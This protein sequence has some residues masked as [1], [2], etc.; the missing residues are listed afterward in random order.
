MMEACK[1]LKRRLD[2][3]DF[4]KLWPGFHVFPFA[5]YDEKTVCFPDRPPIPWDPRFLGNTAIDYVGTPLA[6]WNVKESPLSDSDILTAKLVHEMFHAFQKEQ[7]ETRWADEKEGLRYAYD[8]ENLCKKYMENFHLSGFNYSFSRETW[9]ILLAF[10]NARAAGYPEAVRYESRVETIE[11][12]AQFVELE[13]LRQ[14]DMGKF[15]SAVKH[16][17]EFLNDPKKLFPIRNSCY[18]SGTMMCII[19]QENGI[20]FRHEIGRE[21]RPLFEILGQGIPAHDHKVRIQTVIA[22][23]QTFLSERHE[24]V[25]KFLG[26]AE[27][28]LTGDFELIGFD[29]MNSF[30]DGNRLFSP[31]FL[32]VKEGLESRF[33]PGE[34]VAMIDGAFRIAAVFQKTT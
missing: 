18:S 2:A 12:I 31:G 8:S 23:T 3:L 10:R 17:S 25:E 33:L 1:N 32:M 28:V 19:A 26:T 9:K 30:I 5:L 22:E 27:M 7:G 20:P 34:S 15:R 4:G 24:R 6:I 21:N 16:I 11:G 13:V 14:L 29:P